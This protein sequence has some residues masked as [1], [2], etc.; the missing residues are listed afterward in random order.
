MTAYEIF[1]AKRL[2]EDGNPL[3][4]I[5]YEFTIELGTFFGLEKM[6]PWMAGK[7]TI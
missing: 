6:M 5:R 3:K 7:A 1:E 4:A 2:P